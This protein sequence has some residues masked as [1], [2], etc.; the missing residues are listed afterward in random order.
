METFEFLTLLGGIMIGAG[1]CLLLLAAAA[2]YF[3]GE[4]NES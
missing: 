3:L 4:F 2:A 1:V